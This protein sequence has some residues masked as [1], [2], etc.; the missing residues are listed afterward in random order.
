MDR[1]EIQDPSLMLA[2]LFGIEGAEILKFVEDEDGSAFAILIETPLTETV[3]PTCASAVHADE[4]V[5]EE[6]PPTTAG[7]ADLLIAWKRRWWSCSDPNCPQELFGERN[8]SIE[9]FAAR[10]APKSRWRKIVT[11]E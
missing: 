7:P 10:V 1:S 4:P 9:A 11:S 3:C 5:T 2:I 8:E 6:L